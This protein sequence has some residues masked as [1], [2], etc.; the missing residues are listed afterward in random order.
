[1]GPGTAEAPRARCPAAGAV[2]A[3]AFPG[4]PRRPGTIA[5]QPPAGHAHDLAAYRAHRDAVDHGPGRGAPHRYPDRHPVGGV[6]QL[7]AGPGESEPRDAG[8]GGP[9]LLVGALL[10]RRLRGEL[11]V[12]PVLGIP[13]ARRGTVEKRA[14][15]DPPRARA[16]RAQLCP[17]H[18][19][20]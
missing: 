16:R 10:D 12:A 7:L 3:V 18:P 13:A 2:R 19:L 6:P 1:A 5:L 9:E 11:R 8:R 17:D 4:A 14:L 15:S 20:R